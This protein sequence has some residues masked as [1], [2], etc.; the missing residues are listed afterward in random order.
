[1]H[2]QFSTAKFEFI[3]VHKSYIINKFYVVRYNYDSVIMTDNTRI[4]ISQKNQKNV[5][6]LLMQ[7]NKEAGEEY[8]VES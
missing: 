8:F 7:H 6:R 3:S 5:R 1:M 2:T 4:P